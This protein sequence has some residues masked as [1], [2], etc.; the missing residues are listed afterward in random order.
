MASYKEHKYLKGGPYV[1]EKGADSLA[2]GRPYKDFAGES[3][4]Q[5]EEVL[6]HLGY[7]CILHSFVRHS[8]LR[9]RTPSSF[10]PPCPPCELARHC[11]EAKPLA[12]E[13]VESTHFGCTSGL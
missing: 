9:Q 3:R 2:D 4:M 5:N 10:A 12:D 13:S 8:A 11:P 6:G 7:F 1:K